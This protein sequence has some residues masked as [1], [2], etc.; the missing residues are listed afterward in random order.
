MFELIVTP[1]SEAKARIVSGWATHAISLLDPGTEMI[2]RA[3]GGHLV[4]FVEDIT[5]D[6]RSGGG[7][8]PASADLERILRFS[9]A[10]PTDARLVVHCHAG[11]GRSPAAALAILIQAGSTVSSAVDTIG[12]MRPW[13][14]PNLAILRHA[15]V[16]LPSAEGLAAAVRSWRDDHQKIPDGGFILAQ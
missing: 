1:L 2:P 3:S 15:E 14:S 13:M 8:T 10:L 16:L 6:R 5:G 12:H 9:A 4:V 7:S 11:I